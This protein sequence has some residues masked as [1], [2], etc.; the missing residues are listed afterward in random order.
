[1]FNTKGIESKLFNLDNGLALL[2][3]LLQIIMV[4]ETWFDASSVL[5][6]VVLQNYD[7]FR[8]DRNH[9]GDGVI[10]L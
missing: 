8:N 4:T 6:G 10:I 3:K 9:H 7:V 1:M 5:H 2:D